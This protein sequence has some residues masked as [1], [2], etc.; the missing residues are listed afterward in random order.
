M[1]LVGRICIGTWSRIAAATRYTEFAARVLDETDC[2]TLVE[3]PAAPRS[4]RG[5]VSGRR[6]QRTILPVART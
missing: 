6:P 2:W 1:A 5:A 4:R 3:A